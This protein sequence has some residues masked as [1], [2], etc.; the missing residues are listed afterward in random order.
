[1]ARSRR[2]DLTA[3]APRAIS[4]VSSRRRR[5]QIGASHKALQAVTASEING[6]EWALVRRCSRQ[7]PQGVDKD[8]SQCAARD[9]TVV[10]VPLDLLRPPPVSGH[11]VV[12]TMTRASSGDKMAARDVSYDARAVGIC[13]GSSGGVP[14]ERPSAT[15]RSPGHRGGCRGP[16]LELIRVPK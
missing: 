10:A 8:P 1:V 6:N 4:D 9:G 11:R 2:T 14:S 7:Q 3:R 15:Q 16:P 12:D 13:W 5:D